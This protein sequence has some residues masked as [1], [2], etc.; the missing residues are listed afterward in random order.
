[1][2]LPTV[3]SATLAFR[4]HR[5]PLEVVMRRIRNLTGADTVGA[6]ARILNMAPETVK[7]HVDQGTL[8]WKALGDFCTRRDFNL[9]W[10]VPGEQPPKQSV[11]RYRGQGGACPEEQKL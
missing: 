2:P 3:T 9:H 10:L 1:M 7:K 6:V 4:A 8:P 5:N 11:R